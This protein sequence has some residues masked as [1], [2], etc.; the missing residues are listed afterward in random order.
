MRS[1][2]NRANKEHYRGIIRELESDVHRLKEEL[3]LL[4][5]NEKNYTVYL[6]DLVD[7]PKKLNCDNC[8]EGKLEEIVIVNRHIFKCETCGW[9]SKATV[10]K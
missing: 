4:K 1:K 10:I 7:T 6:N 2:F 5:N 8:E 9:R 3:R